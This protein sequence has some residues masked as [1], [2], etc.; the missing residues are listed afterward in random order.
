MH[1]LYQPLKHV[2]Q[3]RYTEQ[4]V[5][6][7]IVNGVFAT[8]VSMSLWPAAMLM[9]GDIQRSREI[10]ENI[11]ELAEDCQHPPT[12]CSV[13]AS[14]CNDY[15]PFLGD[16]DSC[17]T[18]AARALELADRYNLGHCKHLA[19]RAFQWATVRMQSAT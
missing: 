14:L 2:V 17:K 3:R 11:L 19:Q 1:V 5:K 16:L 15:L 9:R 12:V 8:I 18:L 10:T 4:G 6:P 13:L 7:P